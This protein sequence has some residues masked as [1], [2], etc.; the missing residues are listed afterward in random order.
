MN[1]TD[2]AFGVTELGL[3]R[4]SAHHA[5][6]LATLRELETT[7]LALATDTSLRAV[8]LTSSGPSFA[9]GGDVREIHGLLDETN[10]AA[11]VQDTGRAALAALG[12]LPVPVI[13]CLDG[14]ALGGGAELALAAD[15]RFAGP[16]ASLALR[17]VGMGLCP[18]WFTTRRLRQLLG[19]AAAAELLLLGLPID[20]ARLA[21]LGLARPAPEGARTEALAWAASL[22]SIPPLALRENTRL[23]RAAYTESAEAIS[24]QERHTFQA[25]FGQAEHRE[26]LAAFFEKRAPR[27]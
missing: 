14:A 2:H 1:R 4:P 22:G 21:A 24:L 18:A 20:A 15:V 3:D 10:A 11:V 25:L 27:F 9:A 6:D 5:L 19:Y 17:Q 16:G 8:L 12:A 23:L 26:A 13:A 7:C